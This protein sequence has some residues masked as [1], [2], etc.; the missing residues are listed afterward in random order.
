MSQYDETPYIVI[1]R[2]SAGIGSFL[3]GTLIGAGIGLL[4]APRSG[5]ETREE[6]RSGANKLRRQAEDTVRNVQG[7]VYDSL[8]KA[9]SNVN[10]RIDAAR[11]AFEAG[12][13]AARETRVDVE[14]RVREAR[15]RVRSGVDDARERVRAGVEAA[16]KPP[17]GTTNPGQTPATE[18]GFGD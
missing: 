10:E 9:K 1:E 13:Q 5:E 12:R 8:D 15:E 2:R 14:E 18:T 7:A 11:D 4:F 17:A 16:R 6:L 3:L